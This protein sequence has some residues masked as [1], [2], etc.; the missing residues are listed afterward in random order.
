M[1][2]LVAAIAIQVSM[3]S[4]PAVALRQFLNRKARVLTDLVRVSVTDAVQTEAPTVHMV[5]MTSPSK[6]RVETD[7]SYGVWNGKS[8]LVVN[9]GQLKTFVVCATERDVLGAFGLDDALLGP[10]L[11]GDWQPGRWTDAADG[12][13]TFMC[14]FG[15]KSNGDQNLIAW[16]LDKPGGELE[17][18]EIVKP[19][20]EVL[21]ETVFAFNHV[22][23]LVEDA[24]TFSVTP[25][26]G[27][28]KGS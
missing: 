20:R 5:L 16:S 15:W 12:P 27:A 23:K 22:E 7:G 6:L 26:V 14:G 19:Q 13:K 3:P 24:E 2:G 25:P 9:R 17:A 8:G 11:K 4:D 28:V 1:L 21:K 18:V 10:T